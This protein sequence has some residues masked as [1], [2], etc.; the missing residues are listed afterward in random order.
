MR[1]RS[2]TLSAV[3][4]LAAC[5][6]DAGPT[7]IQ[8]PLPIGAAEAQAIGRETAGEIGG[9]ASSFTVGDLFLFGFE[10]GE[11]DAFG[12]SSAPALSPTAICPTITPMPPVDADSDRV[13]DELMLTFTLPE[14]SF[15]H[16]GGTLEVTGTIHITDPTPA[17]HDIAHRVEFGD[18]QKKVTLSDGNFFLRRLAGARQL[19]RTDAGFSAV[20][21]TTGTFESSHDGSSSLA[22]AWVVSFLADAGASSFQEDWHLPSGTF[23]INGST[24]RTRGGLT[25]SLTVQTVTPLHFDATC[26][27]EPKFTAGELVI[28]LTGVEHSGTIHVVFTGCGVP[29]TV[30]MTAT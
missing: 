26:A 14:C 9:M 4:A 30:T 19:L 15:S 24:T 29:P 25:R 23:T 20:D 10:F 11:V 21:S 16:D 13:P 5:S 22:K 2:L 18:L 3:L 1:S 12:G 8:E 6:R 7:A 28:T 17:T 27:A